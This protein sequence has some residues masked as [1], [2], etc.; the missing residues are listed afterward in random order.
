MAA[1]SSDT[2]LLIHSNTDIDGDTSIV[3]SS[4][5]ENVIDRV[6]TDPVYANATSFEGS[7]TALT[8][9]SV[10]NG[11]MGIRFNQDW[12]QIPAG[13]DGLNFGSGNWTAMA[14][15]LHDASEGDHDHGVFDGGYY[16]GGING[17]WGL[18]LHRTTGIEFYQN[19]GT[20][21]HTNVTSG[22]DD[23]DDEDKKWRHY[24]VGN[25]GTNARLFFNGTQVASASFG[26]NS[27]YGTGNSSF[28]LSIG[29]IRTGVGAI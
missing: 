27:P 13:E 5:S 24:L 6:V 28:G 18:R 12:I 21:I 20:S 3:D 22:T 4:A 2:K 10:T 16:D 9:S 19:N 26:G 23:L 14:W 7:T 29:K 11:E 17:G 25:D 8:R 1:P 15:H